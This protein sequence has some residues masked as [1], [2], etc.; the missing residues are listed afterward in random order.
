MNLM[1]NHKPK[2]FNKYT[3]KRERNPNIAL[4]LVIKSQGERGREETKITVPTT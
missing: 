1:V 2:V 3:Q 4:K